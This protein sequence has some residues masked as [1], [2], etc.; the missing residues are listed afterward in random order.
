MR[1]CFDQRASLFFTTRTRS[2]FASH[3]SYHRSL[4]PGVLVDKISKWIYP[5]TRALG[6]SQWERPS[7]STTS[8]SPF[9]NDFLFSLSLSPS[10]SLELETT[11]ARRQSLPSTFSP[12]PPSWR[13]WNPARKR[14]YREAVWP[15]DASSRSDLS[16]RRLN[17]YIT[18]DIEI[19]DKTTLSNK[20]IPSRSSIALQNRRARDACVS[21]SLL[22]SPPLPPSVPTSKRR[23]LKVG[24]A[25]S[26]FRLLPFF[27]FSFFFLFFFE[28]PS[29]RRYRGARFESYWTA[30]TRNRRST[31]FTFERRAIKA[32][33]ECL[34]SSRSRRYDRATESTW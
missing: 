9:S 6:M 17:D 29:K 19:I 22:A 7:T 25:S 11:K 20:W 31:A 14:K 32:W 33:R 18:R 8:D 15:I 26:P 16:P 12:W 28:F 23:C 27:L 21:I 10:F 13:R 1:H 4:D 24:F 2:R 34:D 3:V 5:V 30:L